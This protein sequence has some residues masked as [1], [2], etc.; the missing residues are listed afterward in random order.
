MISSKKVEGRRKLTRLTIIVVLVFAASILSYLPYFTENGIT[1]YLSYPAW[2]ILLVGVLPARSIKMSRN[3]I[4]LI[5]LS[6]CFIAVTLSNSLI[7]GRN[8]M[9]ASLT[10]CFLIA[11]LIYLVGNIVGVSGKVCGNEKWILWSYIVSA[12]ILN[13][14]IYAKYLVEQD[15]ESRKYTY[16]SKNEIAFINITVIIIVLFFSKLYAKRG[17]FINVSKI[18]IVV[19]FSIMI[20]LLRC[21]SMLICLP[22]VFAVFMLRR[23]TTRG[24]RFL[25]VLA[26]IVFVIVLSNDGFYNT[27]INGILFAGRDAGSLDSISSGRVTQVEEAWNI[28]IDNFF[29][30]VGHSKTVDCF[31]VSVLMKFGV[32]G[33]VFLFAI[34]ISPLIWGVKNFENR[35]D[36]YIVVVLCAISYL[37]GGGF[38]EN[39][40]LGPGVRCFFLWFFYGYLC[41]NKV[42]GRGKWE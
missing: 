28:F 29:V 42:F 2:I 30:G 20:A 8:Y 26:L 18:A 24:Q 19:F 22:I 1:Y 25:I 12:V 10:R 33:G 39:A 34:A 37:L 35:N 31:Y 38:E 32:I 3:S 9:S 17:L 13:L 14:V 40:P 11:M 6:L 23:N 41:G 15:L 36:L 4:L 21:R 27:F 5:T 7:F 16:G